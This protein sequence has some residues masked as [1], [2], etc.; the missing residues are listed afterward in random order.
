MELKDALKQ[1]DPNNPEHWTTDGSPLLDPLKELMGEGTKL[2][3][4]MVTEQFPNFTKSNPFVDET[5]NEEIVSQAAS[6]AETGES[7]IPP[8]VTETVTIIEPFAEDS[9]L[10]QLKEYGLELDN[11]LSF[12][13]SERS[14][15]ESEIFT[16][17]KQIDQLR[18]KQETTRR[19]DPVLEYLHSRVV[20]LAER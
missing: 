3:R 16:T 4:A 13:V 15:I 20:N 2:T 14:R 12:L 1:L 18:T 19:K 5:G 17:E 8:T 11:K 9:D 6:T 7:F 10:L